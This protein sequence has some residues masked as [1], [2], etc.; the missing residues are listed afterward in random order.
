MKIQAI[1][2]LS[3][4]LPLT[5]ACDASD[6]EAAGQKAADAVQS[7]GDISL[8]DI[9]NNLSVDQIKEMSTSAMNKLTEAFKNI[10]NSEDAQKLKDTAEPMIDK[11]VAMK[12]KLGM[13]LPGGDDL[14]AAMNGLKGQFDADSDIMKMLQPLIDQITA[15]FS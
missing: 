2:A 11:L 3:L 5:V 12:D 8:D 10:E 15:L 6:V 1:L 9:T 7:L 14:E 4:A 13:A